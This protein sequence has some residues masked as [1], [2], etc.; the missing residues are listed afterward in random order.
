MANVVRKGVKSENYR[1]HVIVVYRK[2]I[3]TQPEIIVPEVVEIPVVTT[4]NKAL[5]SLGVST[6]FIGIDIKKIE[7]IVKKPNPDQIPKLYVTN[8]TVLG[9]IYFHSNVEMLTPEPEYFLKNDYSKIFKVF[10]LKMPENKEIIGR[11]V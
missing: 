9:E 7:K 4:E 6:K 10:I 11:Y 3:L 1:F 8:I 2:I 5:D